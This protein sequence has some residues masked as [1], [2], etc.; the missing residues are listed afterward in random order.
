MSLL[1]L[2]LP[3]ALSKRLVCAGC[4]GEGGDATKRLAAGVV[5]WAWVQSLWLGLMGG[6][7]VRALFSSAR[8]YFEL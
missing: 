6:G 1:R 8:L 4:G 5:S 7:G 2:G 3:I